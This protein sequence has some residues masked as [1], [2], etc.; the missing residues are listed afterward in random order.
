M[1]HDPY[2]A[3]R[4]GTFRRYLAGHVL[5]VL[6]Q[7]MLAVAVGWELYERTGSAFALG[8]VGLAQVLPLVLFVLPAGQ[9]VDSADRRRVLMLAEGAIALAAL[10]LVAASRLEAP[11]AV[12]YVL[13]ALYGTG[14]TFQLPA[15]QAILP[16]LVPLPA[17]TNAV[18]WNSGG[19]QAADVIGPALGGFLI[20]WTGSAAW[21]YLVCA[22]AALTFVALLYPIRISGGA[23]TGRRVSWS[24]LLEGVRFVRGSPVLLAAM[25]LDLFAVLLGGVVALLPIFAK[26]ILHVGPAG[27]GWLRAAQSL[28]AVSTS[29]AVAHRPPF[30]RAGPALLS[31]VTGF[32]L[33]MVVFGFSKSFVLSFVTLFAAGAC[34][35]VSVVI[36]LALAQLETP[37]FLRGRVSAVNGFFIGMSNEL[38]EFESGMLAGLIGPVAAVVAG[39]VGVLA[40]VG[41]VSA[42]WP[43]LRHL[44]MLGHPPSRSPDLGR[45]IIAQPP[46]GSREP[47]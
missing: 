28:G 1:T 3:L 22:V 9:L 26:D 23:P 46:P 32:G 14:R 37:D 45:P 17:F 30:R 27:L 39:G 12:Y 25:S 31:A 24:G 5:A 34:D 16:N 38:G 15:K 2:V 40:V 6:G 44:G 43:E 11:I 21:V 20:A 8:I 13:L 19:W 33:A 42:T 10:G 35:A 47:A 4:L 36:R 29:V 41:A 7:G 18:A